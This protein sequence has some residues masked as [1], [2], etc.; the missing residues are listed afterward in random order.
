MDK[1]HG[2]RGL[3]DVLAARAGRAVDLHLDVLRPEVH[4]GLLHLRQDGDRRRGRV[5]PPAGLRLGHALHA[6]HAGLEL[7]P[8]I[9]PRAADHEVRLLD[10]AKLRLAVVQKLHGPAARGGIETVHPEQAVRKQGALLAA[11]AGTDLEDDILFV[12]R[13]M[14]QQQDSKLLLECGGALLCTCQLLLAQGLQLG[15]GLPG[16]QLRRILHIPLRRAVGAVGCDDRSQLLLLA[17]PCRR[18]FRVGVKIRLLC[19]GAQLLVAVLDLFQLIQHAPLSVFD[20]CPY[21]SRF[22]ASCLP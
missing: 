15:V 3:V 4:I 21:S 6:V 2:G 16:H 14:G 9:G 12:V 22:P 17:Q 20:P 18:L 11:H 13:I 5:H 19:A 8:G 10:A 7:Q 1:A